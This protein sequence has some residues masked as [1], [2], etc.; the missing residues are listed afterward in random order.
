VLNQLRAYDPLFGAFLQ[1]DPED[2][3][4]R[5][6][7]EGYLLARGDYVG[8]TDPSGAKSKL[9]DEFKGLIPRGW[10]LRFDASCAGSEQALRTA[11]NEAIAAID[12]CDLAGCGAAG[13]AP[14]LRKQWIFALL[15]GDNYCV[16]RGG[17]TTVPVQVNPMKSDKDGNLIDA[18]GQTFNAATYMD[19]PPGSTKGKTL[20]E[21]I[22][23]YGT[24]SKCLKETVAHEAMHGVLKTLPGSIAKPYDPIDDGWEDT[25]KLYYG[26]Q[27]D[28]AWNE[29]RP[30]TEHTT[31][32]QFLSCVS[33][34]K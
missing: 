18:H 32:S 11:I 8:H 1:S 29:N 16:K 9:L 34:K 25:G 17:E 3:S 21:R 5:L 15:T 23:V 7:P 20:G 14:S 28:W 2:Q 13:F 12:K 6:L 33:C 19:P 10:E 22:T 26:R 27:G 24:S 4:A 30:S 31:M